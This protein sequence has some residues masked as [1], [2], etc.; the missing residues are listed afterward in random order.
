MNEWG[1]LSQRFREAPIESLG[2]AFAP[3]CMKAYYLDSIVPFSERCTVY[4]EA[5]FDFAVLASCFSKGTSALRGGEAVA[6]D[7]GKGITEV[8]QKIGRNR[9]VADANAM[10]AHSVFRRDSITGKISH[11]ETF[12]PQSNFKNP[13]PWESVKRYDGNGKGHTNKILQKEIKTPHM[14]DPLCAGGI[15]PPQLWEIPR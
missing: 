12:K 2:C 4:G 11:Y 13:N 1:E 3:G 15:R 5:F 9:F 7:V 8:A 14:H 10:G 6:F